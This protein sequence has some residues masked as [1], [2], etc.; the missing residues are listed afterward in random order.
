MLDPFSLPGSA[1]SQRAVRDSAQSQGAVGESICS[2]RAERRRADSLLVLQLHSAS[3][4]FLAPGSGRRI[5]P[6]PESCRTQ[7]ATRPARESVLGLGLPPGSRWITPLL[8]GS[9][10]SQTTSQD[11]LPAGT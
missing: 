10:G 2:Q 9:A 4:C 5:R 1:G 8:P 3:C 6:E 7:N 11:P